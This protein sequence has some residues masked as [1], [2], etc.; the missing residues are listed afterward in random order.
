VQI[1]VINTIWDLPTLN[2]LPMLM[3]MALDTSSCAKPIWI[4]D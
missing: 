1:H 3:A 2:N 4:Y